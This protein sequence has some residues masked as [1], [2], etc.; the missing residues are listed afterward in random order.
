[1]NLQV[2]RKW[3]ESSTKESPDW[4]QL[5]R[6]SADSVKDI[7]PVSIKNAGSEKVSARNSENKE[8]SDWLD[9]DDIDVI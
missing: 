6:S 4:V 8:S 7:K 9:V 5:S 3:H 2:T 1:M